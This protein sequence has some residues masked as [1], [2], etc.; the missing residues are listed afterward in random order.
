MTYWIKKH[1]NQIIGLFIILIIIWIII[2]FIPEFIILLFHTLLGNC[3]LLLSTLLLFSTNKIYGISFALFILIL[4]RVTILS[5]KESFTEKSQTD[6]IQLQHTINP[7]SIFDMEILTKQVSAEELEYY[8]KNGIWYWCPEVKQLYK[9]AVLK[10][11]YIRTFS[12]DSLMNAQKIYNQNAILQ[13][14]GQQTKE[15]QFLLTGIQ[16]PATEKPIPDGYGEFAYSSGLKSRDMDMIKCNMKTDIAYPEKI[17]FLGK[18][19]IFGE[20]LTTTEAIKFQDLPKFIPGFSF[21]NGSC[22]PCN[23]VNS[24]PKYDCPFLIKTSSTDDFVSPIW[25]YLWFG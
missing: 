14:L 24:L 5:R 15:G 21:L 10:N 19:G 23:A 20:Q 22:N 17:T 16:I 25:K 6:F 11:P 8:N 9:N 13:L 3:L 12:G 2:Y 4:Y 7:N 1:N 18:R